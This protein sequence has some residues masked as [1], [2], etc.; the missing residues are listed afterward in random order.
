MANVSGLKKSILAKSALIHEATMHLAEELGKVADIHELS[1]Y[2]KIP[3]QEIKDIVEL[4][5]D[6]ISIGGDVERT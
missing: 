1:E 2:T 6:A 5:I 3:E 4:S